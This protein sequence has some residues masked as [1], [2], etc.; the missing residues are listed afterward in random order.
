MTPARCSGPGCW[1]EG[2][3]IV[4]GGR[5]M[6]IKQG[7]SEFPVCSQECGTAVLDELVTMRGLARRP[8]PASPDRLA[9]LGDAAAERLAPVYG[10]QAA[11][12]GGMPS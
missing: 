9:G 11:R 1:A 4:V 7:G 3:A 12:R 10:L 8:Q 5:W 2:S 6:S